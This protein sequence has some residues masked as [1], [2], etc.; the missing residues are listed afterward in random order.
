MKILLYKITQDV[1][2]LLITRFV[3]TSFYVQKI[4]VK[5]HICSYSYHIEVI[6]PQHNNEVFLNK[7]HEEFYYK[8]E[9]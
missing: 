3:I 7:P 8:K 6:I 4:P 1:I 9:T 2:T 5:V